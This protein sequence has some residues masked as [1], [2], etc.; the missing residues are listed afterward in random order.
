[1]SFCT[2]K[3]ALN[4]IFNDKKFWK[5]LEIM[6]NKTTIE[7]I[8]P[9]SVLDLIRKAPSNPMT[10]G[11]V[12]SV[13]NLVYPDKVNTT[14]DIEKY[15]LENYDSSKAPQQPQRNRR[16]QNSVVT[17]EVS[18]T[19]REYGRASYSCRTTRSANLELTPEDLYGMTT[20]A[21][22]VEVLDVI[23]HQTISDADAVDWDDYNYES[24]E[25]TDSSDQEAEQTAESLW[26]TYKDIIAGHLNLSAEEMER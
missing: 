21:E 24:E 19:E 4:E 14:E 11:Q 7:S 8:L 3:S 23:L 5:K 2:V 26:D 16:T 13:T 20:K 15:V 22:V 18:S 17:A 1:M 6:E 9:R 12:R 25:A 10:R